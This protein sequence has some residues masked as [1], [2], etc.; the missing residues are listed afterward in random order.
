MF[1]IE[2]PSLAQHGHGDMSRTRRD[3]SS[4]IARAGI[5]DHDL[6]HE[7]VDLSFRQW[8]GSLL[9]DRVLRGEY[10]ERLVERED[11]SPIVT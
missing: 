9:L 7:A 5:A 2:R 1:R 3:Q 10:E 6:Q 4:L 11:S 8:V